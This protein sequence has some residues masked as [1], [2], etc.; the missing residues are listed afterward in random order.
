VLLVDNE[1]LIRSGIAMILGAAP[2]LE[3][4]AACEGAAAVA[5]VKAHRPDVVLLDIRMPDVDGLTVLR[6]LRE[7]AE[8]PQV[9]M[10]TTFDTDEYLSEAMRLGAAG[11]LLKDTSPDLLVRSVRAL[12]TGAGCL[13]APVV[14]RLQRSHPAGAP[15]TAARTVDALSPRERQMLGHLG[16]GLSNT[17][18]GARMHLSVATVKDNVRA[19]LGKLGVA[20]RVQA[21]VLADRLGLVEDISGQAVTDRSAHG[22][23]GCC[24]GPGLAGP[25]GR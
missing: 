14:R 4:V 8:P 19:V 21:A 24:G 22:S 16:R 15:S 6:R 1:A 18:I 20:N 12:A 23:C 2:G 10:L 7:L 25:G 5:A 17:E 13:S 11:F 9:A 3:V